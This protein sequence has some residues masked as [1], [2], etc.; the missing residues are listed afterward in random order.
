MADVRI[1]TARPHRL[2]GPV[3]DELEQKRRLG[4]DA[5]LLVPEQLTLQ[6]ERDLMDRLRLEGL[7]LIDVLSPSRLYERILR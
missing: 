3:A 4:Q 6:A 5:I 7:F 2:F 1:L